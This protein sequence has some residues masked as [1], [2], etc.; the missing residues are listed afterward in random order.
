[1]Q[2]IAENWQTR[3]GSYDATHTEQLFSSDNAYDI[4][5]LPAAFLNA[6][7]R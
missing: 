7:P 6:T 4:P 5:D 2:S 3:P 1:M